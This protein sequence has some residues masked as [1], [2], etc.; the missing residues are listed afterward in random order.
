MGGQHSGELATDDEHRYVHG[1]FTDTDLR[2]SLYFPP[3]E[4]YEGRFLQPVMHIAGDENVAV[5]GELAG[6]GNHAIEFAFDLGGYLVE[7]NQGSTL[8][9][10]APDIR[11]SSF[12]NAIIEPVKVTA[13]M[14]APSAIYTRLFAWISPPLAMPKASG[15]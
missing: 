1:G 6:L 15:A 9:M 13:P 8:M 4:Q 5:T 14:A 12:R 3:A 2:F 7:S 11:P 10:G